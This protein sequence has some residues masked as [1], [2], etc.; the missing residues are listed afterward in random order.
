MGD[1]KHG[2]EVDDGPERADQGRGV[3]RR[4]FLAGAAGATLASGMIRPAAAALAAPSRERA[5]RS[6]GR[7]FLVLGREVI[8][9]LKAWQGGEPVG[10]VATDGTVSGVVKKHIG[11]VHYRDIVLRMGLSLSQ[12]IY[13]HI[14]SMLNAIPQ[15]LDG[16]IVMTDG[17]GKA[18]SKL[19]FADALITEVA[20]P[21]LDAASSAAAFLDVTLAPAQTEM[22]PATGT[23][24]LPLQK[25]WLTKNF[26][27][28]IPGIDET[29]ISQ[30]GA[31]V[32]R[33]PAV[34][35]HP[36]GPLEVPDLSV[37]FA[38]TSAAAWNTWAGS[39]LPGGS[40]GDNGERA[41]Q[42]R[43][44]STTLA[45]TL[46]TVTLSGLGVVTLAPRGFVGG[47]GSILKIEATLYCEEIGLIHP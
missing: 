14:A 46:S 3:S 21:A 44:L 26:R 39:F 11:D 38:A 23:Y 12:T 18:K 31:F 7:A 42:L 34:N 6:S 36:S 47:S 27:L 5:T 40:T 19:V 30:I 35:G 45:Q 37:V 24:A 4:R 41:G 43:Y 17:E 32:V 33:Q 29:K 8:G 22:Q 10:E 25:A 9:P 13:T 28:Q 16:A 15:Q 20:F 2:S 1:R